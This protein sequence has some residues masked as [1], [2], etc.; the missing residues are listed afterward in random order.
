M[1]RKHGQEFRVATILLLSGSACQG[2]QFLPP[3][4][5]RVDPRLAIG[6]ATLLL[7][8]QR[9][10][11]FGVLGLNQEFLCPLQLMHGRSPFRCAANKLNREVAAG[12]VVSYTQQECI[13][14]INQG[15]GW[16]SEHLGKV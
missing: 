10:K 5:E 3:K 13:G 6:Q 8:D 1:Q 9:Q 15:R 11:S 14:Q 16:K 7:A 12:L 4:P 2:E